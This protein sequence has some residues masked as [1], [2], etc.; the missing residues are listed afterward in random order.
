MFPIRPWGKLTFG[1]KQSLA[2]ALPR[3]SP[4]TLISEKGEEKI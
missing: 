2:P 1:G 3:V 4:E